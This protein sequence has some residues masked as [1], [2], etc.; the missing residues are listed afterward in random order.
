MHDPSAW[1]VKLSIS[2]RVFFQIFDEYKRTSSRRSWIMLVEYLTFVPWVNFMTAGLTCFLPFFPLIPFSYSFFFLMP[3]FSSL[4]LSEW[5]LFRWCPFFFFTSSTLP[6]R[7][8]DCCHH[9]FFF[10]YLTSIF[11]SSFSLTQSPCF[12]GLEP[13]SIAMPTVNQ[14][15]LCFRAPLPSFSVQ[16]T[17][18]FTHTIIP[19]HGSFDPVWR[20]ESEVEYKS[21]HDWNYRHTEEML[22]HAH[23]NIVSGR[24]WM[25]RGWQDKKLQIY[26]KWKPRTKDCTM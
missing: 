13:T 8:L 5:T 15:C 4:L 22:A 9:H 2:Y 14:L 19:I 24:C 10:F 6:S 12:R 26:I 17:H 18:T 7:P 23:P 16:H 11:P 3:L 25:N 21:V 20:I 1:H